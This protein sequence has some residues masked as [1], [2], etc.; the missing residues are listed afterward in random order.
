MSHFRSIRGLRASQKKYSSSPAVCYLNR[1]ERWQAHPPLALEWEPKFEYA[2]SSVIQQFVPFAS[3]F[4]NGGGWT[5]VIPCII[6]TQI[7]FY[8]RGISR[9]VIELG[10]LTSDYQ[11]GRPNKAE[12]TR[13]Y[14]NTRAEHLWC[15]Y[16]DV[17]PFSF[18]FFLSSSVIFIPSILF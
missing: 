12:F 3:H 13:I 11:I 8:C 14:S 15:N 17:S 1:P 6:S 7:F 9:L 4:S 10:R 18:P 5:E 16:F 2:F